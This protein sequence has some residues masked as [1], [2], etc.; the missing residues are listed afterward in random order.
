MESAGK[1]ETRPPERLLDALMKSQKIKTVPVTM[2]ITVTTSNLPTVTPSTVSTTAPSMP[3]NSPATD[4][5]KSSSLG[6]P[7]SD[8]NVQAI[9]K[10]VMADL[11]RNHAQTT[12]KIEKLQLGT[13]EKFTQIECLNQYQLTDTRLTKLEDDNLGLTAQCLQQ[14]TIN[15]NVSGRLTTLESDIVQMRNDISR[16]VDQC[17]VQISPDISHI[18]KPTSLSSTSLSGNCPVSYT[19]LSIP[20]VFPSVSRPTGN[21]TMFDSTRSSFIGS[22]ERFQDALAEFSGQIKVL[23][24]EKFIGQIDAYFES[25]FMSPA[26]QLIAAQRSLVGDAQVWYESLIPP[27]R[28]YAEFR[29]SFRQH[30][31]SSATQR[32]ARNEI[33]R[34]YQYTRYDGLATHS[35]KWIARAKYI[36]QSIEQS[37]LVSTIIQHYPHATWNG[38]PWSRSS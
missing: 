4:Q 7:G 20:Q 15:R 18:L 1:C 21:M 24:P 6:R 38:Y 26:Q 23:H 5:H 27:P 9:L 30:F 12:S 32:K 2:T 37:D 29:L 11:A 28:S 31:W 13:E 19:T 25:V 16:L 14:T 10:Q 8:P 35:M 22:Q 34:P 33:F 36:S 17:R 3:D